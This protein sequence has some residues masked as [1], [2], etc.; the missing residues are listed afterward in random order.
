MAFHLHMGVSKN[1]GTPKSPKWMVYN[2]KPY[3]QMDDLGGKTPLFF[4]STPFNTHILYCFISFRC[5]WIR[6]MLKLMD[7]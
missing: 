5:A 1:K 3:E 4:G 2:G 7:S 6:L